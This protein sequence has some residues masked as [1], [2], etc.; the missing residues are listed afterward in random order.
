MKPWPITGTNSSSCAVFPSQN[1]ATQAARTPSVEASSLIVFWGR[2]ADGGAVLAQSADVDAIAQLCD[3]IVPEAR[4]GLAVVDAQAI[5]PT[6]VEDLGALAEQE[7]HDQVFV[8]GVM[9][10]RP[11]DGVQ[12]VG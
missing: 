4:P 7:V 5:G 10:D 2:L 1:S 3:L 8:A 11:D 12:A 6:F 9:P